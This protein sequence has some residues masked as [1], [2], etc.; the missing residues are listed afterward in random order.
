MSHFVL[1]G[2]QWNPTHTTVTWSIATQNFGGQPGGSFDAFIASQAVIDDIAEAFSWWDEQSGLSFQMI[3]DAADVDVRFGY[4]NIPGPAVGL[5]SYFFDPGTDY[6]ES[7]ITIALEYSDGNPAPLPIIAHEIGHALGL[8]HFNDEL[9]IMNA[10][11][12]IDALTGLQSSDI[13]GIQFL[14]GADIVHNPEL[15]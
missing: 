6:F 5:T 3:P 14:Y 10:I 11:V 9:A 12:D 4:D 7:G 1:S 8:D 15:A 13:H 2:Q